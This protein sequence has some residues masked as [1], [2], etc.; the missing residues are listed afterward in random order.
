MR[1]RRTGTAASTCLLLDGDGD[2]PAERA[3]LTAAGYG[4]L[5]PDLYLAASPLAAAGAALR[6]ATRPQDAATARRLA[7]RA[8]PLADLAARY[9]RFVAAYR[10]TA[11]AVAA[12]AR[13]ETSTPW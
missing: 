11:E 3:G 9:G 7:A 12:G 1:R 2:R 13:P 4:A 10:E 5:G 8:W 6:L